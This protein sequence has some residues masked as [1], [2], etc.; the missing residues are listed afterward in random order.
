[1]VNSI[2]QSGSLTIS[3]SVMGFAGAKWSKKAVVVYF[4]GVVR[5]FTIPDLASLSR[6]TSYRS[7]WPTARR[8]NLLKNTRQIADVLDGQAGGISPTTV[9]GD[10]TAPPCRRWAAVKTFNHGADGAPA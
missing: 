1:V 5:A 2:P 10:F 3:A 6:P 7:D 4:D 8:Q 9:H